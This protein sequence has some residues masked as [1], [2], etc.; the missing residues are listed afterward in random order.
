MNAM[1]MHEFIRGRRSIRQFQNHPVSRSTIERILTSA[2]FAPS[3]HNRQPW[4][5]AVVSSPSRRAR[6]AD[7]M[8]AAYQSDL[9]DDGMAPARVL[10]RVEESRAKILGAPVVVVL[11]MDQSEMDRYPDARRREAERIMAVQSTANAGATLL[12]AVHAEGLGGVWNCAPLFACQAVVSALEL[13]AT[14]EPQGMILIGKPAVSSK[15]PA[16][17]PLTDVAAFL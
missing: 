4:R 13:P 14:W 15:V 16:R 8:A 5:F 1:G 11:C 6:L 7:S 17:K 9:H 12:L 2:T 3:A 10:A